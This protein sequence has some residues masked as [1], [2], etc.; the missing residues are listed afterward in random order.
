MNTMSIEER[1]LSICNL[2]NNAYPVVS[3]DA[4]VMLGGTTMTAYQERIIIEQV[5]DAIQSLYI[6]KTPASVCDEASDVLKVII[7]YLGNS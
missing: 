6:K 7:P 2:L 3:L 5:I 4:A 1:A